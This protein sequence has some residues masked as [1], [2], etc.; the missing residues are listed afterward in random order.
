MAEQPE[1]Q[2]AEALN[3][4]FAGRPTEV[5]LV[6][7]A[8]EIAGF[9]KGRPC[10]EIDHTLAAIGRAAK[11]YHHHRGWSAANDAGERGH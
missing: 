8:M 3:A 2:I 4:L 7:I 10:N 1:L 5:V 6:A 11:T 9:Y